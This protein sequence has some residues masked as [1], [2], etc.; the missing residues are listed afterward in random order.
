MVKLEL[1]KLFYDFFS[2][3][4]LNQNIGELFKRKKKFHKRVLKISLMKKNKRFFY[5]GLCTVLLLQNFFLA[6]I[7]KNWSY[8]RTISYYSCVKLLMKGLRHLLNN[9]FWYLV[10]E[11]WRILITYKKK[12][13]NIFLLWDWRPRTLKKNANRL[14]PKI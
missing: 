13:R 8:T 4:I 12:V 3:H 5:C 14:R 9:L 11:F 6:Y 1:F 2:L 10:E 7:Y